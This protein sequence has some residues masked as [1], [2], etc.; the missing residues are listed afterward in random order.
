MECHGAE[1]QEA[2]I[3]LDTLEFPSNEHVTAHVWKR[4]VDTVERGEMPPDYQDQPEDSEKQAWVEQVVHVIAQANPQPI[5]LRRLNRLEYENTVHDLLG[6]DVPLAD[7]LPEDGKVQG[8]DKGTD[9]LSFSSVLIEQ[10]LEAANVAF[11]AAIRRYAPLPAEIR[12]TDLMSV[13]ENIDSVRKKKGGVIEIDNSF[14]KFTPGWPP[15]RLDPVNPIEDGVYRCRIAVWPHNPG[16]RTLAV[17]I[18]EGALF[19]GDTREFIGNFDVT[20]TSKEPRIIEFT[21]KFAEGDTIYV[22]PRIW[23]EHVTWR[24]KHEQRPGVG[25]V[26]A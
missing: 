16:D 21:C 26:W 13:S 22:L 23:P 19:R 12:R 10:Y 3:R 6:I 11:D 2:K 18:Y 14:V 17:A 1:T 8:F 24:D 25:I 5:A 7:L 9:G 4:V 20:G 15:A